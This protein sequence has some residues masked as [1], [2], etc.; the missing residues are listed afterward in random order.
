MST[1][2]AEMSL[3]CS[4]QIDRDDGLTIL[5]MQLPDLSFKCQLCDEKTVPLAGRK[6]ADGG[7]ANKLKGSQV[8]YDA[9]MP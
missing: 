5:I 1:T 9:C 4:L 3:P 2:S 8:S 6:K 7:V